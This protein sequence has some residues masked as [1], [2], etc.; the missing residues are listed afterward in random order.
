MLVLGL[1]LAL[2]L[3][4]GLYERGEKAELMVRLDLDDVCF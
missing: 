4:F 1:D 2:L 3:L